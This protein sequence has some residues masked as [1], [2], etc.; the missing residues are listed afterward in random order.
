[1]SPVLQEAEEGREGRGRGNPGGLPGSGGPP[2]T[3]DGTRWLSVEAEAIRSSGLTVEGGHLPQGVCLTPAPSSDS[4]PVRPRLLATLAGLRLPLWR[5]RAR[6]RGGHALARGRRLHSKA[7]AG[8]G[9]HVAA[10]APAR[11]PEGRAY[12]AGTS[13]GEGDKPAGCRLSSVK[14][15][16]FRE[17]IPLLLTFIPCGFFFSL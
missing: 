2:Q 4:A 7:Q 13:L 9:S 6:R 15:R 11:L 8:E 5:G 10:A 12:T 14:S 16:Y 1:M 17:T 3:S